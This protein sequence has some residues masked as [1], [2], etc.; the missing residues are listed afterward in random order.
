[1]AGVIARMPPWLPQGLWALLILVASWVLWR[2]VRQ[3]LGLAAR[4]TDLDPT[5]ANFLLTLLKYLILSIG[6]VMALGQVGVNTA[7]ILASLGVVGLSLGF[8][9]KDALSNMISGLFIF[10]DRPFVLGDLIEVGGHY[11][12]VDRITMRSTR[13]VTPDGKML[14]VPNTIVVNSIVASYTNFPHLRLDIPFTVG[15]EENLT[16]VRQI[17]LSECARDGLFE[18]EPS[19]RVVVTALNDYNVA[20]E[21]QVWL[22]DEKQHIPVRHQLRERLFEALRSAGV[23]MPFQT[24]TVHSAGEP[25][26]RPGQPAESSPS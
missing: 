20:M 17:A 11:G 19:P 13:V 1:M 24:L 6:V 9:A 10:W 12:R 25:A 3:A 26:P 14:A 18:A 5:A 21:L 8:A 4:R 7:S 15:V 2:L 23:D 22:A 16:R